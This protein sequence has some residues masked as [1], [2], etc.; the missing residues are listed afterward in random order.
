MPKIGRAAK[1][2][3]AKAEAERHTTRVIDAV[4]SYLYPRKDPITPQS[5]PQT[6]AQSTYTLT[7]TAEQA[8]TLYALLAQLRQAGLPRPLTLELEDLYQ[9]VT[10]LGLPKLAL[11]D[12]SVP[13]MLTFRNALSPADFELAELG[14]LAELSL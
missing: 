2:A 11:L 9:V 10:A 14:E 8:L 7:L 13:D 3:E 4:R 6:T 1:T 5:T 12:R